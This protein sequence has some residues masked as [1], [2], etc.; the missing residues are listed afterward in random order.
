MIRHSILA[1]SMLTCLSAPALAEGFTALQLVERAVVNVDDS[2]NR[3]VTFE[4]AEEV[5]PGDE[6]RYRLAYSND[7]AEPAE[8]VR[9]V[10]PVP[11]QLKLIEGS[12][13]TPAAD[14]TY[15]V[16]NG[17]TFARRGNLT[18][19][20]DGIERPATAEEITHIRW[21][22]SEAIAAGATGDLSYRGVLQ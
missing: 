4:A 8:N 16:D 7:G 5:A 12:A 6:V 20:V 1:L 18:V 22:F 19:S 15:S 10:M 11:A 21:T 14:V 2:G 9:L 13:Q 3:D 17:E